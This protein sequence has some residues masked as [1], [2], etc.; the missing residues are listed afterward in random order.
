M[1]LVSFFRERGKARREQRGTLGP[2]QN[3]RCVRCI[4]SNVTRPSRPRRLVPRSSRSDGSKK[5]TEPTNEVKSLICA[6]KAQ[7]ARATVILFFSFVSALV[8]SIQPGS[9]GPRRRGPTQRRISRRGFELRQT[10]LQSRVTRSRESPASPADTRGFCSLELRA[11]PFRGPVKEFG[12]NGTVC[13]DEPSELRWE[14]EASSAY[15]RPKCRWGPYCSTFFASLR[16]LALRFHSETHCT[17]RS[18]FLRFI[19]R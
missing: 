8:Q 10:S 17:E 12:P 11:P 4:I 2:G 1:R 13:D 7:R 9:R 6:D 16:P 3:G 18:C 19:A 5:R 14:F 15:R